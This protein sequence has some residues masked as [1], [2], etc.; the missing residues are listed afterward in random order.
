M[1]GSITD[2]YTKGSIT[3]DNNIHA[4]GG[5]CGS[6]R[7]T[8]INCYA[9]GTITGGKRF[10][11]FGGLCGWNY[12][13]IDYCYAA[14]TIIGGDN[15]QGGGLCGFNCNTITNCYATGSINVGNYSFDIGG[16][17]G[18]NG[19]IFSQDA[20]IINCY[21]NISVNTGFGTH[22]QGGFCGENKIYDSIRN[23]FWDVETSGIG[24]AGDNRD[25][26]IGK[27]TEQMQK[28]STFPEAGW[29]FSVKP[30]WR[31]PY[32]SAGYP[33]LIWGRNIPGDVTGRY[34]VGM[35]D[36]AVL[37]EVWLDDEASGGLWNEAYDLDGSGV[38]D[39][40]DLGVLAENWLAGCNS[41]D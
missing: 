11:S 3:V 21:S 12:G 27:T 9:T 6:N 36:F 8:I 20:V 32:Q 10:N 34:G 35:N 14:N 39:V 5:L 24:R 4:L 41:M 30:V 29:D 17:C 23:C 22:Y 31:M 1:V 33:L 26:A 16:L 37:A 19:D 15:S 40:G 7:G 38:I 18:T 2:C 28:E 25:G 13:S